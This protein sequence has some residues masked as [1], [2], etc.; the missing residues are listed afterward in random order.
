MGK[1]AP[2]TR[3]QKFFK[4]SNKLNVLSKLKSQIPLH[5][6]SNAVNKLDSEDYEEFYIAQITRRLKKSI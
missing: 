3:L 5:N 1:A 4:P 2:W 6:K